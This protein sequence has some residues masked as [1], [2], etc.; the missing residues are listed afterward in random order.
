MRFPGF[1]SIR[2]MSN[3]DKP[4]LD[5]LVNFLK[6]GLPLSLTYYISQGI[7]VTNHVMVKDVIVQSDE[8]ELVLANGALIPLSKV[9]N[10][11]FPEKAEKCLENKSPFSEQEI[12]NFQLPNWN[13]A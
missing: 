6:L 11:I 4:I 13:N 12:F 1:N 9:I 5:R 3:S 2:A 7:S 8:P 10:I